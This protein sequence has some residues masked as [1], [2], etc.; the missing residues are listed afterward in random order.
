ME[1]ESLV[2]VFKEMEAVIAYS[3]DK[4]TSIN[5]EEFE[6]FLG[7]VRVKA[8]EKAKKNKESL[9]VDHP[10]FEPVSLLRPIGRGRDELSYTKLLAYFLNPN[11][12]HGFGGKIAYAFL[13]EVFESEYEYDQIV[14]AGEYYCNTDSRVDLWITGKYG[15]GSSGKKDFLVIIE[16]KVGASV[17]ATQLTRYSECANKWKSN[18]PSGMVRK[19]LLIPDNKISDSIK[20]WRTLYFSSMTKLIWQAIRDEK[21]KHGYHYARF[22]VASIYQDILDWESDQNLDSNPYP[23]LLV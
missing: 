18:N 15:N 14:V 20:E 8:I 12:N 21:N 16:A 13:N 11:E 5:L 22:Y 7:K 2:N 10:M 3:P 6:E 1:K 4:A 23:Y 19:I 9:G 17:G